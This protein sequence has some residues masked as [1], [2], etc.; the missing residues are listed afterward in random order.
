MQNGGVGGY[1]PLADAQA[2]VWNFILHSA[3]FTLSL[4][5]AA[6]RKRHL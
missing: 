4:V 2:A 6:R 3:F 1:G 5:S